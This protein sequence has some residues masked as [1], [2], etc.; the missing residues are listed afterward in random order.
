MFESVEFV[1]T[2]HGKRIADSGGSSRILRKA[3]GRPKPGEADRA[4]LELLRQRGRAVAVRAAS[5]EAFSHR[6]GFAMYA[7]K[8]G[9]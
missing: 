4:F 7:G 3:S 5:R 8:I 9:R 6:A 2:R 1:S